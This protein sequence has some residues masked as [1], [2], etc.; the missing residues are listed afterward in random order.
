MN[1]E[2]KTD[3]NLETILELDLIHQIPR[4]GD[5][6]VIRD[7]FSELFATNMPD[8]EILILEDPKEDMVKVMSP[9]EGIVET[10][11]LWVF[12]SQAKRICKNEG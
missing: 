4:K 12:N 3:N 10:K 11:P 2:N 7:P 6:W 5:V 1:K 9:R 8:I